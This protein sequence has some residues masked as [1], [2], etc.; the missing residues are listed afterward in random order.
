MDGMFLFH[1][2]DVSSSYFFVFFSYSYIQIVLLIAISLDST[3]KMVKSQLKI[4]PSITLGI[5]FN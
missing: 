3:W 4:F 5:E 2:D 1:K